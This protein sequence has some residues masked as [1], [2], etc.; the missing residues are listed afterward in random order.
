M[1]TR[2]ELISTL[3]MTPLAVFLIN[4]IEAKETEELVIEYADIDRL[5]VN[6]IYISNGRN[7]VE[8]WVNDKPISH[9]TMA[10]SVN[11]IYEIIENITIIDF[12][13]KEHIIKRKYILKGKV[14]LIIKDEKSRQK[15]MDA[16][17]IRKRSLEDS[18]WNQ[19]QYNQII[20]RQEKDKQ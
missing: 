18:N 10:D 17:L 6:G 7:W 9:C 2:R 13:K 1:W 16:Y 12:N 14:Q 5:K 11:N 8:P 15:L 3:G 4:K 19:E 20:E